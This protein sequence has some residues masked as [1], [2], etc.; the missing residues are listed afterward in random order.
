MTRF[1]ASKIRL[2]VMLIT[3]VAMTAVLGA[4][5]G[6]DSSSGAGGTASGSGTLAVRM[7]DAHTDSVSEVNVRIVGLTVKRA[8]APVERLDFPGR[9]IELLALENT[10]ELLTTAEVAAGS[11][12]FIQVELDQSQ[13]NV[14]DSG[15]TKPLQIP[16]EKI[17]VQGGFEVGPDGTT[18]LLLDFDAEESL[19]KRGDGQWLLRPV[20]VLANV[21]TS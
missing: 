13:S 9:N 19:V 7:T 3:G 2:I 8:D 4:C 17:K 20:I 15:D 16:S 10:S 6:G 14:V 12:E 18:T 5:G 21:T 11:Y 1:F